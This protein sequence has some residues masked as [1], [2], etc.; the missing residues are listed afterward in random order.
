MRGKL[1][2]A[3]VVALLLGAVGWATYRQIRAAR[4]RPVAKAQAALPVTVATAAVE[5]L[6]AA[7]SVTGSIEPESQVSL[8]AE[9]GGKVAAVTV[10]EGQRVS[11]GQVVVRLDDRDARTQLSQAR[12]AMQAA[13]AARGMAESRLKLALAGARPQE[14]AQAEAAV[15]AAKAGLDNA[16]ADL[17]RLE[18]L[19]AKGAVPAQQLDLA[20]TQHQV[21][22]S[23]YQTASEQLA[24]V[25]EG[26]RIEDI[27]AARQQV[28]QAQAGVAQ[29]RAGVEAANTY[30]S[31][32]II[33]SP[34]TGA[35]AQ[36]SADPGQSIGSG[37]PLLALVNNRQVYVKAK[38]G[39]SEVRKVRRGQAVAV[40][41]DAYPE[42]RFAGVISDILPSADQQTRAF[43]LRVR[44]A[45]P[46]GRLQAGMFARG[47]V[48]VG[49]FTAVT[50]PQLA[51]VEDSGREVVFIV[52]AGKAHAMPVALG[53]TQGDLV[54][55]T[56]GVPAGAQVVVTGQARLRDGDAVSVKGGR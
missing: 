40:T 47:A 31:K 7:L 56:S 17:K 36:R 13:V 8:S 11:A 53:V 29:A 46:A 2:L 22:K 30:L 3:L 20:R 14:R 6:A 37:Q 49:R 43:Y 55:V 5:E 48:T 25:R 42:E 1:A 27:E 21:A 52:S 35:V 44:I 16:Q 23:Q 26:A 24:I 33:R 41:V 15:R 38:V 32:T 12:A 39:E 19:Y 4:S 50:V 34:L 18:D 10:D 9:I 54:E 45:N 51:V 28:A